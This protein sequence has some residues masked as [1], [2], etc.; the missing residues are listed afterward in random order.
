MANGWNDFSLLTI[1]YMTVDSS[2]ILQKLLL[3]NL[4]N[5]EY[6]P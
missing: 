6:A 4:F 3:E 2:D 5:I 1:I